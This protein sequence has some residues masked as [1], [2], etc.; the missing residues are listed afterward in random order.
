[1]SDFSD[2]TM[3]EAP[4]L[5]EQVPTA[6]HQRADPTQH[7]LHPSQQYF[8]TTS[9]VQHSIQNGQQFIPSG[10]QLMSS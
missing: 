10:E 1:M 2:Y 9:A 4:S 3:I 8:I 6:G 5:G 7:Q